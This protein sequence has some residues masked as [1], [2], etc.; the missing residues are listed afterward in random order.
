MSTEDKRCPFQ[1][2]GENFTL[3]EVLGQ[4]FSIGK[5]P[6][7][8]AGWYVEDSNGKEACPLFECASDGEDTLIAWAK[9]ELDRAK[10][11]QRD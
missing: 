9:E 11:S 5:A 1:H 4:V 2:R 8:N 6:P 10:D 7:T 3:V